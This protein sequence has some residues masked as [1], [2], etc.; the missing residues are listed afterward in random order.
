M[1]RT[2]TLAALSAFAVLFSGSMTLASETADPTAR[3][4]AEVAAD[5]R[6]EAAELRKKAES[7]RKLSKLYAVRTPIKGG[8]DYKSQPFKGLRLPRFA[9]EQACSRDML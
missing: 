8:G 3:R 2:G 6:T 9:F 4:D 5:Y 7:H 1:T